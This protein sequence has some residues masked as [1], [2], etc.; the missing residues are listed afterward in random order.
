MYFNAK[1]TGVKNEERKREKRKKCANERRGKKVMA[2]VD[3]WV[4]IIT[5]VLSVYRIFFFILS[6][7]F[8]FKLNVCIHKWQ[9]VIQPP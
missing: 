3:V 7:L 1:N 5:A 9:M 4:I 6:F 8:I 2:L